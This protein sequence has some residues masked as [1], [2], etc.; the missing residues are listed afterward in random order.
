MPMDGA[1][2]AA[3][4]TGVMLVTTLILPKRQTP[5]VIDSLA[6][7]TTGVMSTAMGTAKGQA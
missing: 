7:F 1:K 6:G 3:G 2:I 5:K 4:V